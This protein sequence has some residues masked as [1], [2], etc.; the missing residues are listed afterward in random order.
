MTR[1][2]FGL[3]W[4]ILVSYRSQRFHIKMGQFWPPHHSFQWVSDHVLEEI[5]AKTMDDNYHNMSEI[6]YI[7]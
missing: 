3:V 1:N 6:F 5:L 4:D 7:F 2:V